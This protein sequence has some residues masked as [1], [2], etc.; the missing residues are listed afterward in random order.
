M[1]CGLGYSDKKPFCRFTYEIYTNNGTWV[2]IDV[3]FTSLPSGFTWNYC[4][5]KKSGHCIRE[6]QLLR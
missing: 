2:L 5:I 6:L 1:Y 4:N 3:K